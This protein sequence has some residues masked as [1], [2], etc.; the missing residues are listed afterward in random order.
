[1]GVRLYNPATGRFLTV[2][3]VPGGNATAYTYPDN[4][5]DQFDRNGQFSWHSVTRFVQKHAAVIHQIVSS[6][7]IVATAVVVAAACGAS[8]GIGCLVVG[9][10][11][12][13]AV[14]NT[15]ANYAVSRMAGQR[16]STRPALGWAAS[17]AIR[18][19]VS[20]VLTGSGASGGR[21]L[22]ILARQGPVQAGRNLLYGLAFRMSRWW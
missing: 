20:S 2:D 12:V 4:P 14:A 6:V 11:I 8:A 3:P 13:G 18:G 10:A 19:A 17:G 22:S 7:A 15:G 21:S 9:G 1:M 16:V 5:L